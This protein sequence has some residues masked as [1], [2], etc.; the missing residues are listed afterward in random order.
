MRKLLLFLTIALSISVFA[1]TPITAKEKEQLIDSISIQ[2]QKNYVF[3]DKATAISDHL[4]KRNKENAYKSVNDYKEFLDL[5]AKDIQSVHVDKHMKISYNPQ[6]VTRMRETSLRTTPTPEMM[7]EQRNFGRKEN[8]GFVKVERLPGNIGYLD[9]RGFYR[10]SEESENTVAAAMSFLA[11]SDAVIIDLRQNGGGDPRMVQLIVS[12][13]LDKPVHYNSIYERSTNNTEDFYSLEN[14]KGKK[15]P[16]TDIY[17]LTSKQTFSGAEEFAYNVKNLKRGTIIGEVTGGGAHP[18]RLYIVNQNV[19]MAIPMARAINPFTK[20]NWEGTGVEPDIKIAADK[21]LAK[22]KQTAVQKMIV[23]AKLPQ[24]KARAEWY[25]QALNAEIEPLTVDEKLKKEYEGNY[26]D[27]VISLENGDLY[28][29]RGEGQK[30][31]LQPLTA[32]LFQPEGLDFFRIQFVTNTSGKVEKLI[33]H[34]DNGNKDE[35]VRTTKT[36]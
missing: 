6:Q 16:N 4:K 22:A 31:K 3:P 29:R 2:L 15:M 23:N 24:E 18:T 30:R 25:L 26:Q 7:E 5:L 32:T 12:Y 33:G 28:Y 10:V 20:T 35:S 34:Y 1:Q 27:R 17:I 11:H 36:F 8:F 21:A 13:F 14:V 19:V 9:F